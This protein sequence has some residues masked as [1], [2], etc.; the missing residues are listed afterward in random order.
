MTGNDTTATVAA[1]IAAAIA[2]PSPDRHALLSS[3]VAVA[4]SV[5]GAAACSIMLVD[6][7]TGELVF[8][9]TAGAGK[10]DLVGSRFPTDRGI[11]G[12][13]VS[14]GEALTVDDLSASA[15]FARDVAE[16][17]RYVPDSIMA[18]PVSCAGTVLGVLEVLDPAPQSRSSLGD[19]ELLTMLAGQAGIALRGSARDPAAQH[20]LSVPAHDYERLV[21]LVRMFLGWD[22]ARQAAGYR[23]LETLGSVLSASGSQ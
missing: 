8:E 11:A 4:R 2:A 15:V 17:T 16:D 22:Q 10:A 14:T 20:A 23:M 9:A 19:L 1:A 13:V 6:E 18:A 5:F 21:G 12:W 7:R 3:I